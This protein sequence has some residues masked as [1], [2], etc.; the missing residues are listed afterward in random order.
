M[1]TGRLVHHAVCVCVCGGY[2]AFVSTHSPEIIVHGLEEKFI[3]GFIEDLFKVRQG[4]V[5]GRD[6][7]LHQVWSLLVVQVVDNFR[8]PHCGPLGWRRP[9]ASGLA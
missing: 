1:H 4:D 2:R 5:F 7:H 3:V 6:W 9:R 8:L